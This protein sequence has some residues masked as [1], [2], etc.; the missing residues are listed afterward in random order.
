MSSFFLHLTLVTLCAVGRFFCCHL[1]YLTIYLGIFNLAL[2]ISR[3]VALLLPGD[4][5]Q[6]LPHTTALLLG[7]IIAVVPELNLT[8][9]VGQ[10]LQ[11]GLLYL[12][13]VLFL[14]V[15]TLHVFSLTLLLIFSSTLFTIVGGTLLSVCEFG[16]SA[17][18]H[19][20]TSVLG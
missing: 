18:E 10:G 1:L 12:A 5:L 20:G 11:L 4:L 13:T 6:G 7:V 2:G 8:H 14:D 16:T 17:L 9:V 15:R 3:D 19:L